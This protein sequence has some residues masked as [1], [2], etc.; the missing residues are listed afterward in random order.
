MVYLL[1]E[2]EERGLIER[3]RNPADRRSFL[4]HLTST[5]AEI[6][7]NAAAAL[8]EQADTLLAPLDAAERRQLVDLLR[9][10]ADHWEERTTGAAASEVTR[11]AQALKALD[12]LAAPEPPRPA[13]GRT[14]APRTG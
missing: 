6:Q 4:I 13:R 12:R 7:R 5:G 14:R 1:D 11:Q 3:V 9:R 10:V 2:L 8:A